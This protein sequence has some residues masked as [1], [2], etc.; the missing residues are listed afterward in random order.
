[1]RA[2][3][4]RKADVEGACWTA[5]GLRFSDRRAKGLL[6]FAG[7]RPHRLL[8]GGVLSNERGLDFWLHCNCPLLRNGWTWLGE[9]ETSFGVVC[10]AFRACEGEFNVERKQAKEGQL[11]C[12]EITFGL[13]HLVRKMQDVS[14]PGEISPDP[15]LDAH[16]ILS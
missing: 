11:P 8:R 12:Q 7:A 4:V 15:G 10:V 16:L 1:M 13:H 14:W 3:H 6:Q 9:T 2:V 5:T